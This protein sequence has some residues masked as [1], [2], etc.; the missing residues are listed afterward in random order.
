MNMSQGP[1]LCEA[2]VDQRVTKE[3]VIRCIYI[4]YCGLLLL[5]C[6]CELHAAGAGP[7]AGEGKSL[8]RTNEWDKFQIGRALEYDSPTDLNNPCRVSR[9]S[10]EEPESNL[11]D[12]Q[13]RRCSG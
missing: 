12:Y 6:S 8:E 13:G 1:A 11:R 2:S 5:Y 10:I 3:S 9:I 4:R 7:R